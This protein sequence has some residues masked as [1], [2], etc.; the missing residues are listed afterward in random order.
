MATC[1]CIMMLWK[2]SAIRR[3]D[4]IAPSIERQVYVT[5]FDFF[6]H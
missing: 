1:Q 2:V 6:G 4:V 3:N 5:G